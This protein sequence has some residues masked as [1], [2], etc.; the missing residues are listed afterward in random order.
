MRALAAW[1][2][3]PLFALRILDTPAQ[4]TNTASAAN[5]PTPTTHTDVPFDEVR[6]EPIGCGH[7]AGKEGHDVA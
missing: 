5:I 6:E 1:P 2:Y 4:T 3:S 7:D